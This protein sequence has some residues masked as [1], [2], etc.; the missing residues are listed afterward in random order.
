MKIGF[1][2]KRAFCNNTGLGNYSRTLISSFEN[3]FPQNQ[4]LL[5]T[6]KKELEFK[7]NSQVT[8]PSTWFDKTFRSFWRSNLNKQISKDNLDIFHGLSH[9][10]PFDVFKNTKTVV[11]IHDLIFLTRPQEFSYFDRKIYLNKFKYAC[12]N[13]HAIVAITNE[14]KNDIENYFN[15]SSEKIHVIYQ[16]CD[17]AFLTLYSEEEKNDFKKIN[18][19]PEKFLL[20]VGSMVPRKKPLE[21]VKAY[22]NV[23]DKIKYPLVLVG[24]GPEKEKIQ[25]LIKDN[26]LEAKIIFFDVDT[27][28]QMALL[29][30]CAKL[31]IYPSVYEGFGIPIIEAQFSQ[32]PILTSTF[33]CLPEVAGKDAF[34]INPDDIDLFSKKILELISDENLLIESALKNYKWVQ[35][36]QDKQI[37][38]D[39]MQLYQSLM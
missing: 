30:Q 4:Y 11:T 31:F 9:E 23:I 38:N 15:V 8:T 36:F 3:Y 35:K 2:A 18:N 21:L 34:F 6:P 37:A 14:T 7:T 25:K 22:L 39:Y 1:D 29:Y 24:R 10:I 16:S 32:T 33:S 12:E 26:R 19:L 13:S 17:K 5:Y 20:Y 28:A 27:K